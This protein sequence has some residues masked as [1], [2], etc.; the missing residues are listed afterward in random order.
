MCVCVYIY[1][2]TCSRPVSREL[3]IWTCL[4]LSDTGASASGPVRCD[5]WKCLVWTVGVLPWR[6]KVYF[7]RWEEPADALL[8]WY[9]TSDR[10][11]SSATKDNCQDKTQRDT[12]T[13]H[14]LFLIN[15]TRRSHLE[16]L[17]GRSARLGPHGRDLRSQWLTGFCINNTGIQRIDHDCD[18]RCSELLRRVKDDQRPETQTIDIETKFKLN[19]I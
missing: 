11:G 8:T 15:S 16:R 18:N 10:G 3:H 6:W 19:Y 4:L 5:T 9:T 13:N 2:H 1:V 17:C 7:A 12:E 14:S